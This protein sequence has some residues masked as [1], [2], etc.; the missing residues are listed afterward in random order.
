MKF[1]IVYLRRT[2]GLMTVYSGLRGGSH[3]MF[4]VTLVAL[5][6]CYSIE[7]LPN[8]YMT[9]HNISHMYLK[10]FSPLRIAPRIQHAHDT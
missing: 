6:F 9:T 1:S 3:A 2:D 7:I 5:K 8:S 10:I 4:D